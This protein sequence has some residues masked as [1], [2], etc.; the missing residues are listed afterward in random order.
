MRVDLET[1]LALRVALLEVPLV[2]DAL[3]AGDSTGEAAVDWMSRLERL[4]AAKRHPLAAE[5]AA[6]RGTI[7]AARRGAIREGIALL[8][9]STRSRLVVATAAAALE[10]TVGTVTEA[11]RPDE[12]RFDDAERMAMQLLAVAAAKGVLPEAGMARGQAVR[13]WVETVSADPDLVAGM[14]NLYALVGRA[15]AL[16]LLASREP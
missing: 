9:R 12:N 15:D 4:L 3:Q 6:Q 8:G 14:V 13:L 5:V 2:V 1:L 7:V 16:R 10:R 11:L